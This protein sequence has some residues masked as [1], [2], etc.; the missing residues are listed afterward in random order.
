MTT[1]VLDTS[2]L[3][4]VGKTAL[5]AFEDSKVVIP[6]GVTRQLER[7]VK[8]G[9]LGWVARNTLNAIER[10]VNDPT[11]NVRVELNHV[12]PPPEALP[13]ATEDTGTSLRVAYNLRKEAQTD[14]NGEKV[15]LVTNHLT[16]RLAA[17]AAHLEA[18]PFSRGTLQGDYS[19]ISEVFVNQ[20]VL[21]NL[22]ENELLPDSEVPGTE[23]T[24]PNHGF[25]LR[26]A[27]GGGSNALAVRNRRGIEL[28]KTNPNK[29]SRRVTPKGAE[30]TIALHHLLNDDVDITSLGGPA[31]TGKT[32]LALGA[33]YE[34]VQE[35][36]F[37]SITVFRPL[38]EVGGQELGF[39]P[40]TEEE[41]MLP[42][43]LAITDALK[44]F[45]DQKEIDAMMRRGQLTIS[46]ATHIRGRTINDSFII[47]DEAQNFERLTLLSILSRLG[48][49]SKIVMAWDAAQRDNLYISRGDGI[50]AIVE[51]L[52]HEELAAHVTLTKTQRSRAAQMATD[53]LE[54]MS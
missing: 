15:I 47:V 34:A 38:Q 42:W 46:P 39:L 22:Y 9:E 16:Q 1:Y 51:R 36:R 3:L 10:T 5:T 41:K 4:A 50:T 12:T 25:I 24:P 14:K 19:G 54:E 26:T 37:K 7:W 44:V 43:T 53:I 17:Q 21:D 11:S 40:G 6:L 30:Q 27:T 33:G 32:L 29:R 52:K 49:N 8:D 45:T 23:D 13:R 31:G 2:V 35:G 18:V 28:V 20:E 48:S